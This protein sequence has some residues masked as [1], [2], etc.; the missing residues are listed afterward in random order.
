MAI[1]L[2]FIYQAKMM[3]G[4][5]CMA[6]LAVIQTAWLHLAADAVEVLALETQATPQELVNKDSMVAQQTQHLVAVA[7]A[8]VVLVALEELE[9]L[10]L[11]ELV[12]LVALEQQ[13]PS[14]VHQ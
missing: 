10:H 11:V 3:A 4:S 5:P 13:T 8:A 2:G 6:P 7:A 14:Q 1:H 12:E 9:Q